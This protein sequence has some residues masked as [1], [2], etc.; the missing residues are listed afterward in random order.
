MSERPKEPKVPLG[1]RLRYYLDRLRM[2]RLNA[3]LANADRLISLMRKKITDLT[4]EWKWGAAMQSGQT[5]AQIKGQL[6]ALSDEHER[7][8]S[9]RQEILDILEGRSEGNEK[10][11]VLASGCGM[12]KGGTGSDQKKT[13]EKTYL[14]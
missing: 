11:V 4:I 1:A 5:T 9:R 13:D 14:N 10:A 2:P 6:E 7:L 8:K 3:E 12:P